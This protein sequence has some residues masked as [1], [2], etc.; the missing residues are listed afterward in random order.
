MFVMNKMGPPGLHIISKNTP[1][2][3]AVLYAVIGGLWILLSDKMLGLMV[4]DHATITRISMYKGWV[5]VAFT[6]WLLY[7]LIRRDHNQLQAAVALLQ[8]SEGKYRSLFENNPA[9]I[10]L[11]DPVTAEIV[12][13]N[14]AAVSFYG[15]AKE[16]LVRM[17]VTDININPVEQIFRSLAEGMA[18][19]QVLERRHRLKNGEVRDVEVSRGPIAIE[20]KTYLFSIVHDITDR[21]IAEDKLRDSESM[22]RAITAAAADAIILLDDEMRVTY[23]NSA[24]ERM[25]GYSRAEVMGES[26]HRIV[27]DR[28][29]QAHDYGYRRFVATG[30]GDLIGTTYEVSAL[31]KGGG[32]FPVELAISAVRLMGKWHAAGI[33]RDISERKILEKQL[34][35]GQKMEAIGT[36][37][38]GI[39]H[40]FN[41]SLTAIIGFGTLI[42][43]K[44][45]KDDPL[46][47]YADNILAAADRAADL[48]RSLLSFSRYQPIETKPV[49][50]NKVV[51]GAEKFLARLLRE[52]IELRVEIPGEPMIVQ[53]DSGQ[54]VQ[55][56][57]NFASNGADAMPEGGTVILGV[58][59]VSL[60]E[61]FVRV[62][63]F[64]RC[65]RYALLVFS[66]NGVGMDEE[67]RERIFEPF[68]TTKEMGKGTGLGLSS[69]YGVV[70]QHDGF[71]DCYSEP[72]MGTTFKIYLPIIEEL[73]ELPAES[74]Q[75]IAQG[76]TETI[77][78]AE[79]NMMV[80]GMVS[81]M[82][83]QFGYKVVEAVD[84]EDALAKFRERQDSIQ[85]LVLDVIMP[86]KNGRQVYDEIRSLS[87]GV[88][89]IFTSG[90]PCEVFKG[91]EKLEDGCIFISKPVSPSVLLQKIRELLGN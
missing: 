18:G 82:L 90:Y 51:R 48:T 54:I 45:P 86:K 29:R 1:F 15:Y 89:A 55:I 68:F 5:Y 2:K 57:L 41:N 16:D 33:V 58:Y 19:P 43:M 84:G 12:S 53:A 20:N 70:K 87:P 50:L 61:E 3:I 52:D 75:P 72:G 91:A 6:A 11:I 67:T 10:L 69:V 25:F 76:G 78:L 7:L 37:T 46:V 35:H 34:R 63:G 80:R 8:E 73:M 21:K 77:L 14:S 66:D 65:G 31:R 23:W 44:L 88:K 81:D 64:G 83:V 42:R 85:L 9:N 79:D 39:S 74:L 17:K 22:L 32:E 71:V 28:Y 26:I 24:A 59:L 13:A 62:H 27:P 56:L 40:D 49:D 60:D 47:A 38:G 30:E 4:H 36:L